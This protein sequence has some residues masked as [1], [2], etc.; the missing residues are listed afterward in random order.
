MKDQP[1]ID[2]IIF[3]K[4]SECT[5]PSE[6]RNETNLVEKEIGKPGLSP[7]PLYI[8][9]VHALESWLMAD[10]EALAQVFGQKVKI[11]SD[12]ERICKPKEFPKDAVSEIGK[13]FI[14]SRDNLK[15]TEYAEPERIEQRCP[16]FA[17][18]RQAVLDP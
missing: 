13:T 7:V 2:K 4:D 6:I 8:V 1:N 15:I 11:I 14:F 16:S 9:V 10:S 18:F 12:I 5:D 3:C 17:Q